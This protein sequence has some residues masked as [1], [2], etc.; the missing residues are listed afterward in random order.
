MKMMMALPALLAISL[1]AAALTPDEEVKDQAP[2]HYTVVKGDTLWDI[3][4]RFLKDPWSW[5]AVWQAN[6]QINNPHLIYPGNVILLCQ[7]QGHKLLAVDPGGGCKVVEQNMQVASM[8]AAEAGTD[9]TGSTVRLEPKITEL[10]S[11]TVIPTIPLRLILPYMNKSRVVSSDALKSAPYVLAGPENR[12]LAGTGD[13]VFVRGHAKPDTSYSMYRSEGSYID[14]DTQELLGY[15]ADYVCDVVVKSQKDDIARVQVRRMAQDLRIDDLMLPEQKR[16]ITAVFNPVSSDKVKPGRVLRI[17]GG[18]ENGGKYSVI[19]INR[20]ERDGVKQGYVFSLYRHGSVI[21]D[22]RTTELVRLP[23]EFEG[24]SMVFRT[25]STV[26][27]ALI[28]KAER[29]IQ[30]GDDTKPPLSGDF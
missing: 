24:V 10:A 23:D 27:Y 1:S 4:A 3:A 21:E 6:P 11:T 20:G 17:L 8:A 14:P 30:I 26:S 13:D 29:S 28:L 9:S 16:V 25:F 15:E 5:P 12:L 2:D 18:V 7:I 22:R 19:V